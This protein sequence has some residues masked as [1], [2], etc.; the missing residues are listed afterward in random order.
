MAEVKIS[1]LPSAVSITGPE[2]IEAVQGGANKKISPSQI[3]DYLL[4]TGMV[5]QT[6]LNEVINKINIGGMGLSM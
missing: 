3:R 5:T 4:S 1:A 6:Q 2:L